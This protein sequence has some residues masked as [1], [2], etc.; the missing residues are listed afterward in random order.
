MPTPPVQPL[1]AGVAKVNG[2]VL[3][4]QTLVEGEANKDGRGGRGGVN[5][6]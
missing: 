6:A 2:R 5:G 4:V 3:P 1:V